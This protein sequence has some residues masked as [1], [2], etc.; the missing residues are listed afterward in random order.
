[1][2]FAAASDK[3]DSKY[4]GCEEYFR[5]VEYMEP[6]L[7]QRKE[8]ENSD[9]SDRNKSKK[10]CYWKPGRIVACFGIIEFF[11]LVLWIKSEDFNPPASQYIR[12]AAYCGFLA[13]AAYLAHKL[14]SGKFKRIVVPIIWT[15]CIATCAVLPFLKSPPSTDLDGN[16]TGLLVPAND[17]DPPLRAPSGYHLNPK[18]G[19]FEI[20]GNILLFYSTSSVPVIR[21]VN[22]I[23]LSVSITPAGASVSG[24]FFDKGQNVFAVLESN[25]FVLDRANFWRT[26]Q[27]D[28]NTLVVI[29]HQNVE[30]LNIRFCNPRYFRLSGIF[31]FPGGT[32]IIATKTNIW[33]NA[34]VGPGEIAGCQSAGSV[35]IGINSDGSWDWGATNLNDHPMD[36]VH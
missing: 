6:E 21:V 25:N 1:M 24:E 11:S 32:E 31:E 23:F 7:Q 35:C 36:T 13:G 4:S 26:R 30:A 29:N 12:W 34:G 27:L 22:K 10:D 16:P 3:P 14:V 8:N 5:N 28:K 17:P 20:G 9:N 19:I 15:T 2:L 18:V 33:C